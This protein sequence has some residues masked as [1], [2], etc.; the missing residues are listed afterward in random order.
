MRLSRTTGI[1]CITVAGLSACHSYTFSDS[2]NGGAGGK[3]TANGGG[4]GGRSATNTVNS[5]GAGG[6]SDVSS[7]T[8]TCT[9]GTCITC[10]DGIRTE[11]ETD[12]DCGGS[13]TKK[14]DDTKRCI[15][16][17]DCANNDCYGGTCV[18]CSDKVKDGDESGIDC[19]GSCGQCP[20]NQGC[21]KA[22]D[23]LSGWCNAKVCTS[24]CTDNTKDYFETD[25]DCGGQ[26]CP[27]CGWGKSCLINSDCTTGFCIGGTCGAFTVSSGPGFS[28]GQMV[29]DANNVYWV[30]GTSGNVMFAP[31]DG[32]AYG[33]SLSAVAVNPNSI[34]VDDNN[35]Y[36]SEQGP[37]DGRGLPTGPGAVYY[38][39]APHNGVVGSI[40][41]LSASQ[42][43][44]ANVVIGGGNVFWSAADSSGTY[45]RAIPAPGTGKGISVTTY[46]VN[47]IKPVLFVAANATNLYWVAAQTYVSASASAAFVA[48]T[49]YVSELF[50]LPIGSSATTPPTA[51][52][53]ATNV[54]GLAANQSGPSW[55]IGAYFESSPYMPA[56]VY[57]AV[58]PQ[59]FDGP[60]VSSSYASAITAD[61]TSVYWY[62]RGGDVNKTPAGAVNQGAVV[63]LAPVP[64]ACS[65]VV[66]GTYLYWITDKGTV[67]KIHK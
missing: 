31:K 57:G 18:S 20:D 42:G 10:F 36:W 23:C 30:Q 59:A 34:A 22:G 40:S 52:G 26:D 43:R 9:A 6:S 3:S 16:A 32:S 29:A 5:G 47:S 67:Q 48:T 15:K 56:T 24:S 53:H 19:G 25:V 66:D 2:A 27:T 37:L 17:A 50:T 65:L 41:T 38:A 28:C 7:A 35:V 11:D 54:A 13:C 45:V 62:D 14:C 63:N 60:S 58:Y 61:S 1:V 64:F 39:P 12:V 46:P 33:R 4:A 21:T 51:L 55:T 44:A 49:Y 8:T